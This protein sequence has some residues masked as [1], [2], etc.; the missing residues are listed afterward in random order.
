MPKTNGPGGIGGRVLGVGGPPFGAGAA[1]PADAAA[2]GTA[3][4]AGVAAPALALGVAAAA[5]AL[6]VAAP[7][8]VTVL[9]PPHADAATAATKTKAPAAMARTAAMQVKRTGVE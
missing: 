6:E 9:L 2:L 3:E 5:L 1:Q 8:R 4:T 7:D